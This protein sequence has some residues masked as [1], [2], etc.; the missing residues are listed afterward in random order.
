[1][2]MRAGHAT[3]PVTPQMLRTLS[4]PSTPWMQQMSMPRMPMP[5]ETRSTS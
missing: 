1:M 4:T 5:Q 2:E 3:M